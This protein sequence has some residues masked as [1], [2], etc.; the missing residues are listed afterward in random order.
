MLG[1]LQRGE[2]LVGDVK[3]RVHVEHVV[4]IIERIIQLQHLAGCVRVCHRDMVLCN[5]GQF[6]GV[7]FHPAFLRASATA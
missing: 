3:V 7:G 4:A 5:V 1:I 6:L 2:D